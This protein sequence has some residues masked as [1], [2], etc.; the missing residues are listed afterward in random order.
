M[1]IKF[2]KI[3]FLLVIIERGMVIVEFVFEGNF[4][5]GVRVFLGSFI[6]EW[7]FLYKGFWIYLCV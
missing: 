7:I 4:L 5:D 6:I 3:N 2:D 1:I